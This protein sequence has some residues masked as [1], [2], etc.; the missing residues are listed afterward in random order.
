[1]I[2]IISVL[3]KPFLSCGTCQ[4]EMKIFQSYIYLIQKN[5]HVSLVGTLFRMIE[6]NRDKIMCSENDCVFAKH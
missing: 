3:L 1:M 4:E 6:F 2:I 5:S